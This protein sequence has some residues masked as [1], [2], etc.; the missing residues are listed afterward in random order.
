MEK[1][2]LIL[3]SITFWQCSTS[4]GQKSSQPDTEK[5]SYNKELDFEGAY[6]WDDNTLGSK[7]QVTLNQKERLMETNALPNHPT[8]DFPRPGNPNK[9][10][11]QK[12]TYRFPLNPS[13][14][15]ESKPA[16]EPGVALNGVKFEP[17]TAERFICETGEVYR[18]EAFQELINLGLDFNNAHVQPTGA[19][20]YHGV[21]KELIKL[22]DTGEDIMLVGYA[23]DGFPMYYSKSGKYK[24]SYQLSSN[25][26]K[27]DICTYKNP[28]NNIEKNLSNTKP[29]GT[30]VSDWQYVD[31]LGD[32]D[33]CN[34]ITLDGKYC[35]FITEE[36]PYIGRCL[37]GIF[38]E[39]RPQ[40]PPPGHRHQGGPPHRHGDF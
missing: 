30:F 4:I 36:Y 16:R 7:T 27:G 15:G 29:D 26:R 35:Y 14:S 10:S 2:I 22:L 8:G 5:T 21:P 31:K 20:H 32:L 25:L 6:T 24:P 33:E 13:F 28:K 1:S 9:I 17:Q 11:P 38:K 12:R 37:K 19:Y 23:K 18:V 40:G 34:G 39:E 3:L